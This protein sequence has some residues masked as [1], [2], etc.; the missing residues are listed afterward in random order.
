[1][2]DKDTSSRTSAASNTP[3]DHE[4][5][6]H[7]L[8]DIG[9]ELIRD[10]IS[11]QADNQAE[12]LLALE[13]FDNE[14]LF[15]IIEATLKDSSLEKEIDF[16]IP[17][18][19]QQYAPGLPISWFP[20]DAGAVRNT[21]S[22]KGRRV[23]VTA[24]GN[25]S[26][27]TDTLRLIVKINKD[28][29][30]GHNAAEH[31][32]NRF[33]LGDSP[34]PSA[35][36][37][38]NPDT[39]KL[40]KAAV[41][42]FLS[43]DP[44][45]LIQAAEYLREV[46]NLIETGTT[47][48]TAFGSALPK[49]RLPKDDACFADL[50]NPTSPKDWRTAFDHL[51]RERA[52][53]IG[54]YYDGNLLTSEVLK[55]KLKDLQ[56]V[57]T[58]RPDVYERF[59]AAAED[60]SNPQ[61]MQPLLHLDWEKDY[62]GQFLTEKP[63]REKSSLADDTIDVLKENMPFSSEADNE[64]FN[65][66]KDYLLVEL[67]PRE[68]NKEKNP[69]SD[70]DFY[71]EYWPY[72]H[73]DSRLVHR[74]EKFIYDDSIKCSDFATGLLRAVIALTGADLNKNDGSNCSRIIVSFQARQAYAH[75]SKLRREMM[76]YFNLIYR[77]LR[78]LLGEA[79]IWK[80]DFFTKLPDPLLDWVGWVN[81]SGIAENTSSNRDPAWSLK[82]IISAADA[83]GNEIKGK[84][85][86]LAWNFSHEAIACQLET[87]VKYL[88]ATPMQ[89]LQV[90]P[91]NDL[92][93]T[94]VF[95]DV[96]LEDGCTLY[97][98][99]PAVVDID[100]MVSQAL[101]CADGDTSAFTH[102]YVTFRENYRKAILELTSQG[103]NFDNA[104]IV[105]QSYAH[106]LE[107][108][109]M[110]PNTENN[111]TKL[112]APLLSLATIR[113]EVGSSVFDIVPPWHPLRMFELSRQHFEVANAIK[114][115]LSSDGSAQVGSE[116]P[117][118]VEREAMEPMMPP[119]LM[120]PD[121]DQQSG[122]VSSFPVEHN[123]WFTLCAR[124]DAD[125]D[126]IRS[127]PHSLKKAVKELAETLESY[128]EVEPFDGS[129]A[130]ILVIEAENSSPDSLLRMDLNG[131]RSNHN[132][133]ELTL[134]TED[135]SHAALLF[136]TLTAQP[137]DE[138]E[139]SPTPI[140]SFRTQVS[141]SR[142]KDLLA[143]YAPA[144]KSGVRPFH[145]ALI[146]MLGAKESKFKWIPVQWVPI[147]SAETARPMLVDRR[148]YDF[149]ED[150]L[151]QVLLVP[152]ELT[153]S[154]A[155]FLRHVY[156]TSTRDKSSTAI[157]K[158]KIFLPVREVR[159]D[160]S[161]N[162]RL[163]QLLISAH[164]LADWI[165][166]CDSMLTKQQIAH[167]QTLIIRCKR[168]SSQN[169]STIISSSSSA[170]SLKKMLRER[171]CQL[172]EAHIRPSLDTVLDRLF[173]EAL[174][175]S[176]YVG[177]RAAKHTEPAGEL[178]GLCLSK[179]IISSMFESECQRLSQKPHF[180]AFLMLDDYAS[181]FMRKSGDNSIA[182]I[183]ALGVA[184]DNSGRLHL[185]ILITESKYCKDLSDTKKSR[186]QLENT[187]KKFSIFLAEQ[188]G[189]PSG[190]LSL[191]VWFNRFANMILD[192]DLE[193]MLDKSKSDIFYE[194][195]GKIR[196]GNIEITLNG[197]S[198]Y[199]GFNEQTSQAPVDYMVN[200]LK[201][202]QQIFGRDTILKML[203]NISAETSVTTAEC[204]FN[205]AA[206]NA[207]QFQP[208]KTLE[209]VDATLVQ[210]SATGG[211]AASNNSPSA[212]K[213]PLTVQPS[214]VVAETTST[215]ASTVLSESEKQ[216]QTN[217]Y[218]PIGKYGMA[219]SALIEE[220]SQPLKFSAERID[221]CHQQAFEL[222]RGFVD[223]GISVQEIRHIPT[224]NGCLVIY[225]GSR[226]LTTKVIE[227]L[228]E[229]LLLTRGIK[230]GFTESAKGE[231]RIFLESD[232]RETV[233]M[234]N[235]WMDR[236]MR[237]NADGT[238][239]NLVIALKELDGSILYLDPLSQDNEAHTLIAGGTGSGK[240]VLMRMMIL[241]IAATNTPAQ[242]KIYII[243]PKKGVDYGSL[244]KLPHLAAPIISEAEDTF[245]TF[246]EIIAE[247]ER[248]YALFA[249]EGNENLLDYNCKHPDAK[250]PVIWLIH[251]EL[252][253]VMSD[254]DYNRTMTPKITAIATKA[255]A[256]GIYL[257]LLAQRPDKDV[258]PPQIRDNIG[259]RLALKLPTEASS[260]IAL[261]KS[262][263]QFLLGHGHLA[264][265][266][267]QT[268]TYAQCPFLSQAETALA[269]DAIAK[270][271]AGD[272]TSAKETGG[273]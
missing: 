250:L 44:A 155:W 58:T 116:F 81:A 83:S 252:A 48:K 90:R 192:A 72:I 146:S 228:K 92:G 253:Q 148:K 261:D 264:A 164:Q 241:D 36:L 203:E 42:G 187:L 242:A 225:K 215:N 191:R 265:K 140:T 239:T 260:K 235:I 23:I 186:Q 16:M 7:W 256:A 22:A 17:Q 133:I 3:T 127:D 6:L 134:Q 218:L 152:P 95:R 10:E 249:N 219:L 266:I 254:K 109:A 208:I 8:G 111:R 19:L 80:T 136:N 196:Q 118:L 135:S 74:W 4:L 46:R 154:T 57:L 1:M 202:Y 273:N 12:V 20:G 119:M 248:R 40:T 97:K 78:S 130:K 98:G 216:A 26:A 51:Y 87:F 166:T 67:K 41:K 257:I 89:V 212:T 62:V 232:K 101:S 240:S 245:R 65:K 93:K 108:A 172:G 100:A 77:D 269:V 180:I 114:R 64:K 183:I 255:R 117:D 236:E 259:N 272:T 177:L 33:Q 55:G 238:N 45:S 120:S 75:T 71:N 174:S 221:W 32:F 226:S 11:D 262:G 43:S 14:V 128:E 156:R 153:H 145:V 56:D 161:T 30:K 103:F 197:Y 147:V 50:K 217:R 205:N 227:G 194:D 60:P 142:L 54:G 224:P 223:E 176:G 25:D 66:A 37:F 206:L 106:L 243:D 185:H 99:R 5:N 150:T 53:I 68:K 35:Q 184:E 229:Q 31:W 88:K 49:L 173:A 63:I 163:G 198:H 124:Q 34:V 115:M 190:S 170:D 38:A 69:L 158:D 209:I 234:W 137:P 220:R 27:P 144:E 61:A 151:S 178:I 28:S 188:T 168:S 70:R 149:A 73:K 246:D 189:G 13:K 110:L 39:E 112:I 271:W 96:S 181:W 59:K 125:S 79:A 9:R 230:I 122:G 195:L 94:G 169:T 165:V 132:N 76:I 213:N 15:A 129:D 82:L 201:F 247:M 210:G 171:L 85:I 123:H 204:G 214:S 159:T 160:R 121:S 126:V 222:R 21:P 268:I 179:A 105:E 52:N 200:G 207:Y 157:E 102:A 175:I 244:R 270:D 258:M 47:P 86:T 24:I 84:K 233:S 182:D 237:R 263:A 167:N 113:S 2:T 251:D 18:K 162:S 143:E 231:S 193:Q 104:R 199:F 29:F 141:S 211:A 267:G 107:T 139:S 131:S 91:A 138:E